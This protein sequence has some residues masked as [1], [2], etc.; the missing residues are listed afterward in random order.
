VIRGEKPDNAGMNLSLLK[1]KIVTQLMKKLNGEIRHSDGGN[2]N[3]SLYQVFIPYGNDFGQSHDSINEDKAYVKMGK[4]L[5]G[6]KVAIIEDNFETRRLIKEI[7]NQEG[8]ETLFLKGKSE[9]LRGVDSKKPDLILFDFHAT[10][11]DSAEIIQSIQEKHNV[12][13]ILVSSFPRDSISKYF[14]NIRIDHYLLK[15]FNKDSLIYSINMV[16]N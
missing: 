14:K 13:V 8:A 4:C 10:H 11:L 16:L 9:I 6:R 12:P 1:L 3:R 7:L 2:I 5:R 15:P